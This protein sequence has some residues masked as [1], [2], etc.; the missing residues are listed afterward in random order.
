MVLQGT[1]LR[2]ALNYAITLQF[3]WNSSKKMKYISLMEK[4]CNMI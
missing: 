4:K 1:Q 2:C 3:H